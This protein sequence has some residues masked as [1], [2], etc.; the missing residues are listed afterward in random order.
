MELALRQGY[1]QTT[2]EQ[3][4]AAA[5]VSTRTFSRYFATKDAVYLTLIQDFVDQVAVE[6]AAVPLD[7]GPLE[8][9]RIA[10]VAT[11]TQVASRPIGNLS[12]DRIVLMLRVFNASDALRQA[13]FEFKHEP[14]EVFV[15]RRMGVELGDRR[16]RLVGAVFSAV[17]VTACSDLIADTDGAPL[18]PRVMIDR[19]NQAFEQVAEFTAD[20]HP[21]VKRTFE[22]VNG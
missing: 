22:T 19:L 21:P 3:I 6:L 15:A 9:L 7:I 16:A 1:D 12:D 8:A 11:L 5:D 2:V 10:H 13:S 17:I 4:A 20:L 14:A 18:G